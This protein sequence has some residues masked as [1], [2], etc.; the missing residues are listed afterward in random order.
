MTIRPNKMPA[1]IL[2]TLDASR[3]PLTARDIATRLATGID[4]V[5]D[6]MCRMIDSGLVIYAQSDVAPFTYL[7][8]RAITFP[9]LPPPVEFRALVAVI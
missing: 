6:C 7:S 1:R 4:Y 3:E 9:D 8:A 2:A 5:R